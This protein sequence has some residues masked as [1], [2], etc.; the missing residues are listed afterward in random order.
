MKGL[1]ESD[2]QA[3]GTFVLMLAPSNQ[4]S[5]CLLVKYHIFLGAVG[6]TQAGKNLRVALKSKSE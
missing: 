4:S 6:Q 5:F 3:R 2:N 1:S